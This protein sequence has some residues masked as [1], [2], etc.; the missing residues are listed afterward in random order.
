MHP[1]KV[2]SILGSTGSIG[3]QTLQ[4]ISAF[5]ERFSIYGL[6]AGRNIDLLEQQI[7][8][9]APKIVSVKEPHDQQ[10]VMNF[11][12]QHRLHTEVQTG[13]F[14]LIKVATSPENQLLVVA[15]VG[16][17]AI[18]PTY[19]AILAGIPIG[20]A[21]KEVLVSAGHH[22][23]SAA[24]HKGVPILPIDSEHAAL[25]Q[26][27][28]GVHEN[29]KMVEKLILTASGGPFL[30]RDVTTFPNITPAD[31][32]KHPRW[33]MGPK[34]TVDSATLMNKGLEVIE[35]HH[36][37]GIG[38][39]HI[40]VLIHPQSIVHSAVEFVD[41]TLLAQMGLPDMRFPIQYVLT[42]PEK[43]HNPWPKTNLAALG[44][45]EFQVPDLNKFELLAFALHCG[46][47]GGSW[48]AVMN[49]ANEAAV[50]LFL[51]ETLS[52]TELI[53]TVINTTQDFAHLSAPTLQDIIHI[54][55]SV[56]E[57]IRHDAIRV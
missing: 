38:Y 55:A 52:F 13:E 49:A 28:A 56:K 17:A 12:A 16:T 45:L 8:A 34:I 26:C 10:R 3:K 54:D 22:I 44:P 6:T 4:I 46:R 51:N 50:S 2:I 11:V 57:K 43:I 33:V 18:M 36:L 15:V 19:Q 7:L 29:P 35:A 20:L 21:C 53:H 37:F 9:F 32:L 1:P 48:P 24:R 31:A 40:E 41:G 14:G 23:M 30:N 47:R 39:D 25:K 42:Y 27:L 5:P